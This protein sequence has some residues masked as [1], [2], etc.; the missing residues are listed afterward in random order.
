MY[1]RS[2]G[3]LLVLLGVSISVSTNSNI[4]NGGSRLGLGLSVVEAFSPSYSASRGNRLANSHRPAS[5]LSIL[6]AEADSPSSPSSSADAGAD[7]G[8]GISMEAGGQLTKSDQ[9]QQQSSPSAASEYRPLQR[10]WWE[11]RSVIVARVLVIPCTNTSMMRRLHVLFGL[12]S[13]LH[14]CVCACSC[15][16]AV[17]SDIIIFIHLQTQLVDLQQG[18]RAAEEAGPSSSGQG[19]F[20]TTT[21]RAR[22]SQ[23]G[24]TSSLN[25]YAPQKDVQRL[26]KRQAMQRIAATASVGS[27]RW[28][29][30]AGSSGVYGTQVIGGGGRGSASTANVIGGFESD[31]DKARRKRMEKQ[32]MQAQ[33]QAQ[34]A[35]DVAQL[36]AS[37][38]ENEDA[39]LDDNP[40]VA[41]TIMADI[42][43]NWEVP[44]P[45]EVENMEIDVNELPEEFVEEDN[46]AQE[47]AGGGA[48]KSTGT[49]TGEWAVGADHKMKQSR[50][51]PSGGRGFES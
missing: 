44:P 24:I 10:Q 14:V 11:V 43:S 5:S 18:A 30:S 39:D 29:E 48:E 33:E 37:M 23:G 40:E 35:A 51:P 20:S 42:S 21:D 50:R 34:R 17:C 27:G 36:A 13:L 45:D 6:Y 12:I 9:Q 41:E 28:H 19:F 8:A 7:A 31:T 49:V 22:Q 38:K 3:A 16:C 4:D 1:F 32:Q 46:M 15:E 25:R 2:S 47:N 26:Q